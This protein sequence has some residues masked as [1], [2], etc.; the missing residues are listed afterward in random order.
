ETTEAYPYGAT[1]EF[2]G[3]TDKPATAQHTYVFTGWQPEIAPVTENATY[4][5]KYNEAPR[6]YTIKWKL[7]DGTVTETY[8]YNETPSFKESTDR[9]GYSFDGWSP[10]IAKVTEDVTYVAQYSAQPVDGDTLTYVVVAAIG[11]V[12]GLLVV[13]VALSRRK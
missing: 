4:E 3:S 7:H 12:V 11:V 13:K 1:P 6:E 9:E 2:K 8:H 10:E 5:A